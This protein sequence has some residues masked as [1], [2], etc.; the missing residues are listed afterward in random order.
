MHSHCIT[1]TCTCMCLYEHC[2]VLYIFIKTALPSVLYRRERTCICNYV[3]ANI[4][5]TCMIKTNKSIILPHKPGPFQVLFSIIMKIHTYTHV[6]CYTHVHVHV[7]TTPEQINKLIKQ[8]LTYM[9]MY[10]C[11]CVYSAVHVYETSFEIKFTTV[12]VCK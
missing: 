11:T 10:M 1:C 9:Y 2:T 6:K 5:H 12:H 8:F 7:F 4:A 3:H